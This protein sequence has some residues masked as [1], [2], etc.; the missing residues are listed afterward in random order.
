MIDY[1]GNEITWVP[2]I[3]KS[4]T[5]LYI[6]IAECIAKDIEEGVL[7]SGA[8]LPPQRIIANYLNI[9]HSTVTRAYKRCEE[10][11]LIKGIIGS[12]TFVTSN[13]GIPDNVLSKEED[14]VIEMGSV[15]PLYQINK[16]IEIEMKRINELVDYKLVL[17]Y[18][19]PE[20]HSKH[21]YITSQWLTKNGILTEPDNILITSGSQNAL[22]VLLMGLFN[23]GDRIAVD[24]FTYT[25][26]KNIT[27]LIG[28]ILIPVKSD[29]DGMDV[30]DLNKICQREKVKGIYLI[31]SCHNPTSI[32]MPIE[33]REA[34]SEVIKKNHMLLIEDGT[35]SFTEV[36]LTTSL[37]D[38]LPEQSF[39]IHGTSKALSPALRISYIRSPKHYVKK[40]VQVLNSLTWMASPLNAEI[41]SLFIKTSLYDK[42]I[43]IKLEELKKRNT[44]FNET[45]KG[46]DILHSQFSMFRYVK[47]PSQL[48]DIIIENDCYKKGVQVFSSKRFSIGLNTEHNALRIAI[49][50]PKSI[51]EMNEGL[52]IVK[53]V[54]DNHQNERSIIV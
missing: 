43:K 30:D 18:A 33:R 32:S 40:L 25:G 17:K 12:G 38:L 22:S 53:E 13:A 10:R 41:V 34:L 37:T 39:Y 4:N 26:I 2:K 45:M 28:I 7:S 3:E 51:E 29:R 14:H 50:S 48:D 31:P 20:G 54:L 23:K 11:G 27:S 1:Y 44:I 19:P 42:I 46:Y 8:K 15:L 49:S 16:H 5:P 52:Q 21:R 47:L 9:N 6:Q 36:E 24:S 35:F